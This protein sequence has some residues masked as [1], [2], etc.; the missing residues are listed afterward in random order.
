MSTAQRMIGIAG[1]VFV[2]GLGVAEASG[3][4]PE[5]PDGFTCECNDD[6]TEWVCA[7]WAAPGAPA[8][9]FDFTVAYVSG[10]PNVTLATADPGW[11]LYSE[12][13]STGLLGSIGTLALDNSGSDD[14]EVT[15]ANGE[16]A[17]AGQ[18]GTIYLDDTG[19]TGHSSLNGK[20]TTL[21]GSLEVVQDSV[22]GGGEVN[23]IILSTCSGSMTLPVV[24]YLWIGGNLSGDIEVTD[25]MDVMQVRGS[26]DSGVT[27]TINDLD[28]GSVVTL[29]GQFA[30][31]MVLTNGI[32]AGARLRFNGNILDST[33]ID[34]N[35]APVAGF[36][37][38][39]GPSSASIINGG[40]VSGAVVLGDSYW[41]AGD[42]TF[43]SVSS[44]GLVTVLASA[45][46]SGSITITEDMAGEVTA[47]GD[48]ASGGEISVG[49]SVS[50]DIEVSN[51]VTGG[52]IVLSDELAGGTLTVVGDVSSA[53]STITIADMVTAG[54]GNHSLADFQQDFEGSLILSSGIKANQEVR[55]GGQ[56]ASNQSIDLNSQAVAGTLK[57]S[58]GGSGTIS[59]GGAVSGTVILADG[60]ANTYSGTATF[61]SVEGSGQIKTLNGAHISGQLN[62]TADCSGDIDI[63]GDLSADIDIG[64][65]LK[66]DIAVDG[67]M[68]S[69]GSITVDGMLGGS[70]RILVGG[71]SAGPIKLGKKTESLTLILV[72]EGLATGAT[73]EINTS[74]GVF[75]AEGDIHIGPSANPVPL[76]FDGCIRIYDALIGGGGGNLKGDLDVVMC[77]DDQEDLNI[78]IDGDDGGNVTLVQTGCTYQTATWTCGT[79]PP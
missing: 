19:F 10:V 74:R 63:T 42:A 39:D 20:I 9:L 14:F 12:V 73:I 30:G 40:A 16:L 52:D 65:D 48:L 24:E 38:C 44:T 79:C 32:A 75:D 15:I 57:I 11:E 64:E 53:S 3:D 49:G 37:E 29:A 69:T 7:K 77:H 72:E 17:G 60:S 46:L 34:L 26:V 59:D 6:D 54:Y 21:T 78:C 27:I 58:G 76:P 62:I 1:F 18:V 2:L 23:F 35:S 50:G 70:G 51:D 36:L 33:Q 22:G 47:A 55:I 25:D 8:H 13:I 28:W 67:D 56:L 5:Y 68:T 66:G 43:A 45:D 71:Q 4:C 61:A 31:D 41:F